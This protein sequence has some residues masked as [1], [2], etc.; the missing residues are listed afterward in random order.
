MQSAKEIIESQDLSCRLYYRGFLVGNG[1]HRTCRL[2]LDL[3]D[4]Q[5]L[6]LRTGTATGTLSRPDGSMVE[7]HWHDGRGQGLSVEDLTTLRREGVSDFGYA[8]WLDA[9][10]DGIET[11][12]DWWQ[13]RNAEIVEREN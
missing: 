11:A 1:G 10:E 3:Q 2:Y 12:L 7:I 5:I 4:N 6:E 8:E 9:V 13:R